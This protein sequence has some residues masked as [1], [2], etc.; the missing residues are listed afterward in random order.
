MELPVF[1]NPVVLSSIRAIPHKHHGM[2]Q[3]LSAATI[4]SIC[5]PV[6]EF[7]RIAC[8]IYTDTANVMVEL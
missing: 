6:V 5:S 2:I 4:I 3:F 8:S 7:E 1:H